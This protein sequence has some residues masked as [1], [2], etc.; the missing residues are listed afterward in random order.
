MSRVLAGLAG[1]LVA[2]TAFVAWQA[3]AVQGQRAARAELAADA[4][5]DARIDSLTADGLARNLVREHGTETEADG[6]IPPRWI[7]LL[8]AARLRDSSPVPRHTDDDAR[9]L[10]ADGRVDYLDAVAALGGGRLARWP[11]RGQPLRV[12]VQPAAR[13]EGWRPEMV[14]VVRGALGTWSEGGLPFALAP[15]SDSS[16]A[17]VWVLW[18]SRIGGGEPRIGTTL[19]V[20]D[21]RDWIVGATITLGLEGPAGEELDIYTIQNAARHELGHALGLDHSPS[22]DDIMAA[23]AGRQDRLS[24][25]DRATLRLLYSLPPGPLPR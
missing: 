22:R 15:A 21:M 17:D 23:R 24:D 4:E 14:E 6:R 5:H 9:R 16:R 25:A 7:L 20:T 19:R 13:L 18:T 1:V 3:S 8:Q 12:W 11:D 10:R 2:G